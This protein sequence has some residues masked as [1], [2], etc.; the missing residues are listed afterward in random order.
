MYSM[1][2]YTKATVSSVTRP[3]RASSVNSNLYVPSLKA[4]DGVVVTNVQYVE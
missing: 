3:L 2:I 1:S 4:G